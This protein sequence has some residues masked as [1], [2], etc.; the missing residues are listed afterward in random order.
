[1]YIKGFEL[2]KELNNYYELVLTNFNNY[3]NGN[4]NIDEFIFISLAIEQILKN[5]YVLYNF[6]LNHL[7]D[8]FIHYEILNLKNYN[9]VFQVLNDVYFLFETEIEDKENNINK[10]NNYYLIHE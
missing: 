2:V 5:N 10:Y 6:N 7:H 4:I 1:M 8:I 9:I 3:F